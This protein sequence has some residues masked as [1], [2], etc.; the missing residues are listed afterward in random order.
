IEDTAEIADRA[1]AHLHEPRS[2]VV[3]DVI[4]IGAGVYDLLRRYKNRNVIEGSPVPWNAAARTPRQDQIGQ[5][6]FLNDRAAAWWN[7]RELLD[8]S[9]GSNIALP[10]DEQLLEELV[11]PKFG[12]NVGGTLKIEEKAE[13]KRRIGRSTDSADAVVA[14][15]WVSGDHH[16]AEALQYDTRHSTQRPRGQVIPYEGWDEDLGDTLG[17]VTFDFSDL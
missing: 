10:D 5:F 7:L 11:A 2:T 13:I 6:K 8:P 17:P 15:F 9:K 12:Y 3:V 16:Q 1:A 4:G 14:C